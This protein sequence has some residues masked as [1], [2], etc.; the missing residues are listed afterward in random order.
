[1]NA[2]AWCMMIGLPNALRGHSAGIVKI[3]AARRS[4]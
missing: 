3:A 4:G 2:I 1:L